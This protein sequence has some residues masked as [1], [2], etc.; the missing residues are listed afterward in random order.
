[1]KQKDAEVDRCNY[2]SRPMGLN[3]FEL[4]SPSYGLEIINI[5]ASND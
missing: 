3:T 5:E 4:Q 1:M 2:S